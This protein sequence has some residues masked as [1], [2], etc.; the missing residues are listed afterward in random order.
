M[1]KLNLEL[2]KSAGLM[3]SVPRA[4]E[5]LVRG[6]PALED[7]ELHGTSGLGLLAMLR[8]ERVYRELYPKS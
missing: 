6:G 2:S 3:A 5:C 8:T 7:P 1:R 4:R